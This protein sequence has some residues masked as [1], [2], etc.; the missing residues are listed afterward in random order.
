VQ[1]LSVFSEVDH[2]HVNPL[3][4]IDLSWS[5]AIWEINIMG[6]LPRV[7]GG[8]RFLFVT[9]DMFTKRLEAMLVVNIT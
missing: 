8:F 9:N 1:R 2:E 7:P 4:T 5:F 3:Q 6:A